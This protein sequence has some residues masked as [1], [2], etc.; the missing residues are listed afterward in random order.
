MVRF[1]ADKVVTEG[2]EFAAGLIL[3][4]PGMTGNAWF[5]AATA[6]S[7]SPG[8]LPQADAQ[9]RVPGLHQVCVVGDPGSFPGPDWMPRQ[10]RMADL[11]AAAAAQNLLAGLGGGA[12]DA[13]FKVALVCIV[14][15]GDQGSLVLRTPT[16]HVRLPRTRALHWRKRGFE[17][18]YLRQ[19][20]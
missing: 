14:D 18:R 13:T 2:G 8:G 10:A 15:G 19:Y 4:M 9:C 1:E 17:Q 11:Q 7:R 12:R 5:D 20:R 3:F 6:L 16:R